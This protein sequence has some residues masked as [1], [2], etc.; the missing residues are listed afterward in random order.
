MSGKKSKKAVR[1]E[2]LLALVL[3]DP[4]IRIRDLAALH[5][6]S[7]ETI[8]RDLQELD[9][10]GALRRTYGGAVPMQMAEPTLEARL[11]AHVPERLAIGRAAFERIGD[12]DHM[13]LCGGSTAVHFARI[14]SANQKRPITVV[15]QAYHVAHELSRNPSIRVM[16][17]PGIFEPGEGIVHGPET[18]AAISR[19]NAPLAI[20]SASALN[21][22]GLSEGILEYAHSHAAMIKAAERVMVIAEH[23]KFERQAFVQIARWSE[24][25]QVISDAPPPGNLASVLAI[26]GVEVVV[27][28]TIE[29]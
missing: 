25:M 8:R 16:L 28:D 20:I 15:T 19:F 13:F 1:H 5:D 4:A 18:L 6:V 27:A 3:A 10:A 9:E 23:Y 29:G 12:T 21:A 11:A 26:E 22:A 7:V 17:L 2:K 24:K 14:L